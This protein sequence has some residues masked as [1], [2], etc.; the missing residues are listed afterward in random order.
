MNIQFLW[1][2][3]Y[4]SIRG[5]LVSIMIMVVETSTLL[6]YVWH[7]FS[8]LIPK[9]KKVMVSLSHAKRMTQGR[10]FRG[11]HTSRVLLIETFDGQIHMILLD[12]QINVVSSQYDRSVN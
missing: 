4:F 1:T 2:L 10:D 12:L 9:R 6:F 11:A 7:C 3:S 5:L 8:L